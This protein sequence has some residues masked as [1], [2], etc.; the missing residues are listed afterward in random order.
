[1]FIRFLHGNEYVSLSKFRLPFPQFYIHVV[2]LFFSQFPF[3]AVAGVCVWGGG[4]HSSH[5]QSRKR[6]FVSYDQMLTA[7]VHNVSIYDWC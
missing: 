7:H 5:Y 3:Y 6:L 2:L 1:M 4:G